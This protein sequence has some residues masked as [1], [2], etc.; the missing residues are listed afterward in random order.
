MMESTYQDVIYQGQ[1]IISVETLP[2]YAHPVAIKKPAKRQLSQRRFQSL[3]NQHEMTRALGTA[4]RIDRSGQLKVRPDQMLDTPPW[5]SLPE[6]R[7][8]VNIWVN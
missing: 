7:E 8:R 3:E 4:S 6:A 2:D 1:A 5:K